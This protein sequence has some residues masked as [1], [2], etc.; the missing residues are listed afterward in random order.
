[1]KA[2]PWT[3][4]GFVIFSTLAQADC[5]CL[6]Y[7]FEPAPPCFMQC[8]K[9]VVESDG[10]DLDKIRNLPSNIRSDLQRLVEKKQNAQSINYESITNAYS[11]D[12]AATM[13]P[14]QDSLRTQPRTFRT[15]DNQQ[16]QQ[17]Q[18]VPMHE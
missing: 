1:M 12:K 8:S 18:S 14:R 11:L 5:D 9:S 16:L 10:K 15:L 3:T 13:A 4:L 7:P 6:S 2:L 17:R